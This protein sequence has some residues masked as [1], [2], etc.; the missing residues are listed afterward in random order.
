MCGIATELG[1]D[2]LG[3]SVSVR[4]MAD[5]RTGIVNIMLVASSA[6]KITKPRSGICSCNECSTIFT[7]NYYGRISLMRKRGR[8]V[9]DLTVIGHLTNL[10]LYDLE[11]CIGPLLSNKAA[12]PDE[13]TPK[14]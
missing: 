4:G 10:A 5:V 14:T 11:G 9:Y 1:R 12:I 6:V 8:I 3:G 13:T 2:S 7:L